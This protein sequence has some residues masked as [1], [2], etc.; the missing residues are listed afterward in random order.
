MAAPSRMSKGQL[1]EALLLK[2]FKMGEVSGLK[3]KKMIELLGNDL[4]SV[5]E[6]AVVQEDNDTIAEQDNDQNTKEEN[7]EMDPQNPE[8]TQYV[9]GMFMDDELDGKNPRVEGLRRVAEEVIGEIIEEGCDLVA[10]PTQDNEMRACVKAWI[11][12]AIDEGTTKRYEALA[13]AYSGNC[14]NEYGSYITAMADTRA[15]GR[16]LRNALKLKRV[17]AA[18]EIDPS[19]VAF[20]E[21]NK[22]DPA[23]PSQLTAIRIVS[24]RIDRSISD[25]LTETKVVT[26]TELWSPNASNDD[27]DLSFLKRGQAQKILQALNQMSISK[28][29]KEK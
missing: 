5:L 10:P 29:S 12:F 21:G 11:V 17:V 15:K 25:V 7:V 9:L 18:E 16:C 23:D 1:K 27:I 22:S 26:E 3:R 13:D 2:G 28:N 20:N 24:N 4:N 19:L 6:T 14:L 8:W